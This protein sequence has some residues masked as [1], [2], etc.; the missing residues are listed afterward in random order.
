MLPVQQQ[1]PTV[2]HK[3]STVT[4]T[5][6]NYRLRDY[7]KGSGIITLHG[8]SGQRGADYASSSR[9]LDANQH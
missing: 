3:L 4:F 2:V 9:K 5:G 1:R 6:T 7:T 8:E